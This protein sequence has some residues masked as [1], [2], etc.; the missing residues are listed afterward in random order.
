MTPLQP[1]RNQ[2]ISSSMVYVAQACC[3]SNAW[4]DGPTRLPARYSSC[5]TSISEFSPRQPGNLW[6]L[7]MSRDCKD[8]AS[9]SIVAFDDCG[10]L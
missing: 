6:S 5:K 1:I 8:T 7:G 2:I 10:V 3:E 4:R 9:D